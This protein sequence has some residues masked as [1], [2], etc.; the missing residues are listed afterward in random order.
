MTGVQKLYDHLGPKEKKFLIQEFPLLLYQWL[1]G[2]FSNRNRSEWLTL[3][4]RAYDSVDALMIVLH[5]LKPYYPFRYP[6]TLYRLTG[7][8]H[9]PTTPEVVLKKGHI[10]RRPL[11]S[12]T[13]LASPYVAYREPTKKDIILKWSPVDPK[14]V[15]G[16]HRAL[17][18]IVKDLQQIPGS[19]T[20]MLRKMQKF[21]SN[22][23]EREFLVYL[24]HP[25]KCTWEPA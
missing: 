1:E 3:R 2:D 7:I 18:K 5:Y 21:L 23:N 16:S 6:K 20:W 24:Y 8:T 19:E 14:C 4:S 12:W 9:I 25:I 13:T 10:S 22:H 11:L 15:V 17:L